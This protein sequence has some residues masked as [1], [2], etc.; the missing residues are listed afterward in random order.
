MSP[1]LAISQ[2]SNDLINTPAWKELNTHATEMKIQKT[3][4]LF[5]DNPAR[6]DSRHIKHGGLLFDYSR[7]RVTKK[8]IDLLL[9]L[10]RQEKLEEWRDNM[11]SGQAINVTENRAVLHTA[12]RRPATDT[13]MVDGENVMPFVEQVREQMKAFTNAVHNGEIKGSIG[14]KIDTIVNIGIGGSDLGPYMVCETLKP[15]HVDGIQSHFVSNVDG[16]HISEVLKTINAETT[17]FLVASKTFT[18][19][20]TM[21]NANTAKN[22]LI[23][24]LGNNDAVADHFAAMSTNEKAVSEFGI[25]P[26]RM[27]PFENWVGGRFSLWSAIGLSI[28]LT[29]GYEN[30]EK[31]LDGAYAMDKHFQDAPLEENIPVLM[32]LIGIWNR[33][34]LDFDALAVIPYDQY[35]H[36]FS[37]F[38]QQLDMESNG[39]RVTRNGERVNYKT[40]PIVFGEPGTNGQH[41]FFQLLHQG[42]DVIPCDFIAPK[43]SQN[44]TGE[45]H[46]LLL[47][48][49]IAQAE[50]M[51]HGRTLEQAN[52]DTQRVFEGNRPSSILLFDEI[53]P[54]NLGQLIALYEH[55]IFVQGII[56]RLN[57]FDQFGVEL[58]KEM[59]KGILE[60]KTGGNTD[61]GLLKHL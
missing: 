56:W 10:A 30:F 50:A 21:A 59:A 27:F 16:T 23:E 38:L 6:F 49:M 35:L 29:I 24:K 14:K 47:A 34:F 25:N 9:N 48:N 46:K 42:T 11:F 20:E 26:Q 12:L 54:Y 37:A 15:W 31:L 61:I 19:Q 57:S 45:H 1:D 13:V 8:T 53:N 22:W 18:T 55:K 41:A 58:G 5:A 3:A 33:N 32:A 17:L 28:A 7:Q 39:K 40:G 43:H 51:M 60:S 2:M 44:P 36:R 4:S 52:G